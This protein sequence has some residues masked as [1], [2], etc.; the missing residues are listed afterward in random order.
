M[1]L[2][3]ILDNIFGFMDMDHIAPSEIKKLSWWEYEEYVKRLNDKIEREN[4]QNKES[5]KNQS[6]TPDYSSKLPNMNSM[7]NNMNKYKP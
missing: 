6:S 2:T 5:Q 1:P 4:K 7:M 3:N